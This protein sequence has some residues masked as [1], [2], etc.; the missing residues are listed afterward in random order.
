MI[1]ERF[2]RQVEGFIL[3]RASFVTRI[4][5]SADQL[6]VVG[7]IISAL[8]AVAY[9]MD[10]VVVG[11]YLLVV[12]GIA[13]LA[14]G[15][16]ARTRGTASPAGAFFDSTMD[17]VSDLLIFSGIA[18][19]VASTGSAWG[20]A[21]VCWALSG[22][23]LTSYT[24]ARAEAHLGEFS[25]GLMERAERFVVLIA[26]SIANLLPWALWIVAI[27]STATSVQRILTARRLLQTPTSGGHLRLVSTSGDDVEA[28]DV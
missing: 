23:V 3:R 22:T 11:G 14:D 1:K 6:T 5:L 7:V 10:A 8:A 19:G 28:A 25:I 9:A 13:D 26:F 18:V 20:T 12:A 15:V 16:I 21:L 24:R 27:G 2:A 4:P 17:R